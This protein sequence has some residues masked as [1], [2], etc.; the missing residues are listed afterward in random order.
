MGIMIYNIADDFNRPDLK[1][2]ASFACEEDRTQ[3]PTSARLKAKVD[4][5]RKGPATAPLRDKDP[6]RAPHA[7]AP[8]NVAISMDGHMSTLQRAASVS[9]DGGYIADLVSKR[10]EKFSARAVR[11]DLKCRMS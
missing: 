5:M 3:R 4:Q 1:E 10:N 6:V 7:S 11:A 9:I 8:L 2:V